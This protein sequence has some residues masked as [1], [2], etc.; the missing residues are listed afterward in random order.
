MNPIELMRGLA[1]IQGLANSEVLSRALREVALRRV[2]WYKRPFM[3]LA[4]NRAFKKGWKAEYK[5]A[6]ERR[7]ELQKAT[8]DADCLDLAGTINPNAN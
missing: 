1:M 6:V 7:A 5:K 3:R 2:P 4:L 8:P